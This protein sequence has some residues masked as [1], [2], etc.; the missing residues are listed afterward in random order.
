MSAKVTVA[1]RNLGPI[2]TSKMSPNLDMIFSSSSRGSML[3]EVWQ[4][5]AK[6][7]TLPG[8]LGSS[9]TVRGSES[10]SFTQDLLLQ[11]VLLL[12][13]ESCPYHTESLSSLRLILA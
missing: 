10:S 13:K 1:L 7:R 3:D 5:A 8:I 2:V 6:K 9:L 12:A 4:E 11:S